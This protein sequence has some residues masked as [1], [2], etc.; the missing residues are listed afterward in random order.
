VLLLPDSNYFRVVDRRVETLS[1]N[2]KTL[3]DSAAAP[4]SRI[5]QP[6]DAIRASRDQGLPEFV[7]GAVALRFRTTGREGVG[8]MALSIWSDVGRPLDEISLSYCVSDMPADTDPPICGGVRPLQQ[9]LKGVD[10][11][12]V[13]AEGESAPDAAL[14][15]LELDQRGVIGVFRENNCG[16][17]TYKVWELGT[18]GED[19]RNYLANTTLPAFGPTASTESLTDAGRDLYNLLFPLDDGNQE[20]RE[21]RAAFER[22]VERDL[23]VA[24]PAGPV[25]SIF[26]RT[27]LKGN[28]VAQPL[29]LPLGLITIP[30]APAEFVGFHYRIEVPLERQTYSATPSCISRWFFAV[31]PSNPTSA[32]PLPKARQKFEPLMRQWNDQAQSVFPNIPELRQ[33]LAQPKPTESSAAVV[34]VSHHDQN[35]LFFEQ[36][37]KLT[38]KQ[39]QRLFGEASL[40][41][42]NGCST[43]SPMALDLIRQFNERGVATTIAS[44]VAIRPEMAGDFMA[45]LGDIV[46]SGDANGLSVADVFFRTVQNLRL[47]RADDTA[48]PYGA[49]ALVFSLLGNGAVRVCAPRKEAA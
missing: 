25:R 11:V 48:R 33:W 38:S 22:F 45:T 17:C 28:G 1:I 14:H 26:V 29:Y 41:I 9:T 43:G 30:S 24:Q 23:A 3:R 31:P 47:K 10:S 34:V 15:F 36:N 42:L 39:V 5:D 8:A 40:L 32:D 18:G 6:L 46:S 16:D 27:L 35:T 19:F 13:A 2:L 44:H 20:R 4:S 49:R 12:R 21:A 37:E 7:F